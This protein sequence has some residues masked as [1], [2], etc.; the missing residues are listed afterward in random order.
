MTANPID[1]DAMRSEREEMVRA[2]L[3]RR[4]IADGRVLAAMRA[5][6]REWFVG[7]EARWQAYADRALPIGS[8]QTI[9][10]PFMVAL[11][12]QALGAGEKSHVLEVGTGSG[13]QAAILAHVAGGV[14][15][16]ERHPELA[17]TA[18]IRLRA[19]GLTNV[20]VVVGDGTEGYPAAAPY[21][22]IL[23]TAGAPHVPATLKAQLADGGR[24]V[25]PVGSSMQQEL[26]EIQRTGETFRERR[27]E[28]CI[29]VP[30][31]G[32]HGWREP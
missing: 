20:R 26:V 22:R 13:Y 6:P 17:E 10:Q 28:G 24:L 7:D 15:T 1:L 25:I 9:S 11:M 29:F 27:G 14:V 3:E 30:L 23:V 5:V 12:T 8:G 31:V 16:I 2:Q 32:Q 21:D 4:G 18:E 19:L